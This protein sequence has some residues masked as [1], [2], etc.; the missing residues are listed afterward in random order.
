MNIVRT[1]KM[2]DRQT[3]KRHTRVCIVVMQKDIVLSYIILYYIVYVPSYTISYIYFA[4]TIYS[5]SNLI[6]KQ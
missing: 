4:Y 2:R 3:T 6:S 1:H 5:L